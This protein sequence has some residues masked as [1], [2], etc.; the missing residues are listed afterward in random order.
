MKNR[1]FQM[2]TEQ[3]LIDRRWFVLDADGAVLGRLATQAANLLRGKGKP[4]FTPHVDCG[5]FVIVINAAKVKLTGNKESGKLYR[6]HTG[7]PGG[8]RSLRAE[9]VRARH[10]ERL[11]EEA[12]GGMLPKNRLGRAL[13]T[14]LKIYAGAEHPHQ[15]QK[16]E[17]VAL[18]G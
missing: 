12:V 7:Y 2:T 14:K 15:A 8:V 17:P 13:A 18:A 10:P 4:T 16:P 1:T 6:H 9:E 3:G 5:D 11:I